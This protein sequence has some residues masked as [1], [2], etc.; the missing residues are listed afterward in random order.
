[1][2]DLAG[3]TVRVAVEPSGSERD[4]KLEPTPRDFFVISALQIGQCGTASDTFMLAAVLC[5]ARN[6]FRRPEC[7]AFSLSHYKGIPTTRIRMAQRMITVVGIRYGM[8]G[9]TT[10]R[11]RQANELLSNSFPFLCSEMT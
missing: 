7:S 9:V 6:G 4:K 3:K 8:F 10:I 1:V 11:R 5:V 2:S